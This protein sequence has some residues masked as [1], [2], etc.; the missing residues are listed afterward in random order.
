MISIFKKELR[1]CLKWVPIGMLIAVAMIWRNLPESLSYLYGLQATLNSSLGWSAAMIAFALG[2]LQSLFDVRNDAR[3]Y[4]LHRPVPRR[5][6]FWAKVAAGFVA[7]VLSLTPAVLLAVVYLNRK[8]LDFLPVS[9][10]QVVSGVILSLGAFLLHPVAMWIGNRDAKWV[11]TR[12]LP[13]A[14]IVPIILFFESCY[15]MG[16]AQLPGGQWRLLL[17]VVVWAVHIIAF[18]V[19]LMAARHA[20]CNRQ[21]LPPANGKNAHSGFPIFGLAFASVVVATTVGTFVIGLFDQ[22]EYV[23]SNRQLL[24]N[25]EGDFQQ[26]MMKQGYD[27]DYVY[28]V[29][30]ADG[31]TDEFAPVDDQWKLAEYSILFSG[32]F[33]NYSW[34]K[35]FKNLRGFATGSSQRGPATFFSHQGRLLAYERERLS[36]IVTPQNVSRDGTMP[37]DHFQ[38]LTSFNTLRSRH[39]SHAGL[40][41]NPLL[42]DATGLYQLDSSTFALTPLLSAPVD[43][44]CM[45]FADDQSPATLWTVSG[46]TLTQYLISSIDQDIELSEKA[47]INNHLVSMP[48]ITLGESKSFKIDSLSSLDSREY[49]SISVF[50]ANDG[51]YGYVT[52]DNWTTQH[53]Y[54]MLKEDG[55]AT[56]IGPAVIPRVQNPSQDKYALAVPPILAIAENIGEL[57]SGLPEGITTFRKTGFAIV[58]S[59]LAAI[60]TMLLSRRR[61]LSAR[62]SW[63]WTIGALLL[64]WGVCLAVVACHRRLVKEACPH[65]KTPTR[66][67]AE[68]CTQCGKAWLPPKL[69]QIEIFDDA[70]VAA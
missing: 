9:G 8:G 48:L 3:G 32:N 33:E 58:H 54:G 64:G 41:A 14:G 50:R 69:D 21:M 40:G 16:F 12:V 66:V 7:F 37:V 6:I 1:D 61:D 27:N 20:F 23:Y 26:V 46:D 11:G 5:Q 45:L 34:F 28:S 25:D 52:Y 49:Y 62:V 53:F 55:T 65:C 38:N 15:E 4:L 42:M 31:S 13:L 57:S 67:D 19:V 36:A 29:R 47:L 22:S 59:L 44:I 68:T 63:A 24:M 43:K 39:D 60:G 10:F 70:I 30:P 56:K 35:Q 51:R 2:L 17:T 18:C